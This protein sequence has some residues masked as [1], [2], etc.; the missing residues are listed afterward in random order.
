MRNS[1]PPQWVFLK[2]NLRSLQRVLAAV[3]GGV[4]GALFSLLWLLFWLGWTW[5]LAIPPVVGSVVGYL[6]GDRGIRALIRGTTL[7]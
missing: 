7:R 3:G 4:I 2:M 1:T 6:F 5:V